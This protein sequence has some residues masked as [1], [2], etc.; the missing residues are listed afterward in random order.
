M[1]I[2]MG[3]FST[4]TNPKK[5]NLYVKLD[6]GKSDINSQLSDAGKV[7]YQKLT[8]P[9]GKIPDSEKAEWIDKLLKGNFDS[10]DKKT[11]ADRSG[12]GIIKSIS[13]IVAGAN[14]NTSTKAEVYD[15]LIG[16]KDTILNNIS[17]NS[18]SKLEPTFNG[19][20]PP[21]FTYRE[22]ADHVL[23]FLQRAFWFNDDDLAQVLKLYTKV[24]EARENDAKVDCFAGYDMDPKICPVD[25]QLGH[26]ANPASRAAA[27]LNV[28]WASE[29]IE[30]VRHTLVHEP[31]HMFSFGGTGFIDWQIDAGNNGA[32]FKQKMEKIPGGSETERLSNLKSVLDEGVTEMFARIVCYR[33][34]NA[35][36][37]RIFNIN[38][39]EDL[40]YYEWPVHLACQIVRDLKILKGNDDAFKIIAKAFYDGKWAAF[41][42]ALF[43]LGKES[44]K[45]NER[46]S[47]DFWR[48]ASDLSIG[49][50]PYLKDNSGPSEAVK[51]FSERF[52]IF[53]LSGSDIL[54]A[55]DD[56]SYRDPVC[57][58]YG[59]GQTYAL[60]PVI[61]DKLNKC[62]EKKINR[63]ET[64]GQQDAKPKEKISV[65][66]D[67][68]QR[69][70]VPVNSIL[71]K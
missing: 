33:I 36:N 23:R 25:D 10:N 4:W 21:T 53:M 32:E 17:Q 27:Y 16:K 5:L 60:D 3:G 40:P 9:A 11:I 51:K 61:S 13:L 35:E 18:K 43:E 67:C 26:E 46:Y 41:N 49:N 6:P 66:L 39:I 56:G 29:P 65:C 8:L 57:Y 54:K 22:K 42:D 24:E 63:A 31:M 45:Y 15:T 19:T 68:K 47:P 71:K 55:M 48:Y 1:P 38:R 59:A 58:K 70:K 30:N 37:D 62:C 50:D 14:P 34:N 20:P 2:L 44:A 52:D 12:G 28:R 69:I 64:K 7:E